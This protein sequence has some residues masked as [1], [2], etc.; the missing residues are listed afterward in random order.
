MPFLTP[1]ALLLGLLAIPIIVMYMLRL[2]RR[3]VTVS[4]TLLW[5]RLVRDRQANAPWQRLRKNLLLFLQLLI[6]AALVL[7]LARPF[8]P[9]ASI[10]SG[11]TIVL[12]DASASMQA[13]DE[14]PT[15]FAAAQA[16]L[17]YII[18]D[19]RGDDLMTLIR[20]GQFPDVL[21]A[22]S[23]DRAALRQIVQNA[24]PDNAA[25]DWATAVA[26][27]NGAAQ[28]FADAR[29][30]IVSDG[31]LPPELPPLPVETI[32]LPVGSSG[33]N[34]ALSALA[35]RDTGAGPQLFASVSNT[36]SREQSALLSI[37]LDDRLF[38][39]RNISV[40]PGQNVSIAVSAPP[41][42]AVIA[43]R[44]SE[45]ETD[46][47]QLDDSAWAVNAGGVSNRTLLVSEGNLFL[48]QVFGVLP[49]VEAFKSS[50]TAY[51]P[52]ADYDLIVFDS[53]P[54]P[55]PL[56]AADIL[57]INPTL[58]NK[59]DLLQ[60]GGVFT[61]TVAIRLA[62]SPLLEYVDW[63]DVHI[64]EA[65]AVQAPSLQTLVEAEGGPLL[66]AG[67]ING[68]R[69]AVLPFDLRAS[70]LPLQIAFPILIANITGWLNPG[71]VFDA[72]TSIKPGQPVTFT[73][74][75]DTTAVSVTKPDGSL[76][77]AQ[78]GKDELIF[79]ETQMP[80]VY[81]VTL[82]SDDASRPAGQFAVNL[83]D[84]AES[85]LQPAETIQIGQTTV[86]TAVSNEQ[87]GQRELWPWLAA[88]AL[89]ILA[90]EWWIYHRGTR[91]PKISIR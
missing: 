38:D 86:E 88:A 21:A 13:H 22:A 29:V 89:F 51:S 9:T 45:N 90:V 65:T 39:A 35:V 60:V 25:A 70:D 27:A 30:V 11:H 34:L 15:R 58:E 55:D 2:R 26:L 48:E 72:S 18:N 66:F 80:G 57:V 7:A 36:G 44:L 28:G 75:I 73:P 16:E 67:E 37:D 23:R 56:P 19:L 62:D 79:N 82:E 5:Q 14:T 17:L 31:R 8:L 47:L 63:R 40:Q 32:F 84:L 64:Q 78:V 81:R 50:P 6:L 42:T 4:S 3:E 61:D 43:A 68:R 1:I 76:W 52:D 46:Y 91:L 20:V 87:I 24:Q 49:G 54:L 41:E 59:S 12:L 69:I 74:G 85:T 83:F 71:S 33:E 53:V 77:R 10:V